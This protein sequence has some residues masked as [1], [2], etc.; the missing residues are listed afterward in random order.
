MTR[1]HLD[2]GHS[3]A[4]WFNCIVCQTVSFGEF[5]GRNV[6]MILCEETQSLMRCGTAMMGQRA[7]MRCF[8]SYFE[9]VNG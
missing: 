6:A 7:N 2:S 8:V 3:E 1:S 4:Q 5:D 9:C